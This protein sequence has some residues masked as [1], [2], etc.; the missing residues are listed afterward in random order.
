M[1]AC[2][3]MLIGSSKEHKALTLLISWTN[4]KNTELS[5]GAGSLFD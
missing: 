2:Q 1:K 3:F 4:V 5:L